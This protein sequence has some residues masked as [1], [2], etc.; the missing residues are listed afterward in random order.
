MKE[1]KE[2]LEEHSLRGIQERAEEINTANNNQTRFTSVF[3]LV[4]VALALV[5]LS[6]PEIRGIGHITVLFFSAA[7][8]VYGFLSALTHRSVLYKGLLEWN[9]RRVDKTGELSCLFRDELPWESWKNKSSFSMLLVLA[10]LGV[11]SSAIGIALFAIQPTG[12][13][14]LGVY[15]GAALSSLLGLTSLLSAPMISKMK[16]EEYKKINN[17]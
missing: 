10:S 12:M 17:L 5:R 7:I 4:L 15:I 14:G 8:G 9:L 16:L 1:L 3:I 11:L 6:H 2:L 13:D